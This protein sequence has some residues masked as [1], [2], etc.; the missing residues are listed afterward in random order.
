TRS[1]NA[2]SPFCIKLEQ[3]AQKNEGQGDQQKK[4]NGGERYEKQSLLRRIRSQMQVEGL[5]SD[6][7]DQKKQNQNRQRDQQRAALAGRKRAPVLF[8]LRCGHRILDLRQAF[9]IEL[10]T[11]IC[12]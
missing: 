12:G 11:I 3:V 7:R 10:G 9:S 8:R 4:D 6:D 1:Q 2:E 5:L